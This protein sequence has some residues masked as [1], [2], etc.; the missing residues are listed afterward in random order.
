MVRPRGGADDELAARLVQG[1]EEGDEAAGLVLESRRQHGDAVDDEGV[2]VRGQ[3][4]VVGRAEGPD[5]LVEFPA[6]DAPPLPRDAERTAVDHQVRGL[7]W[8]LCKVN[9]VQG[10]IDGFGP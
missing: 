8:C 4:D 9:A 2:V 10:L 7:P 6:G 5:D 1:V 3:R